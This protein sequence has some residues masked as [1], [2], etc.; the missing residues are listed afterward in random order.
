MVAEINGV[1]SAELNLHRHLLWLAGGIAA[2]QGGR[3][4]YCHDPLGSTPEAD[5]F[6]LRIRYGIDAWKTWSWRASAATTASAT[7]SPAPRMSLPGP[8]ATGTTMPHSPGWL[9]PPGET[10][11][12]RDHSRGPLD[13]QPPA[14][15]RHPAVARVDAYHVLEAGR[16]RQRWIG[17]DDI[18]HQHE[19]RK[20]HRRR[21]VPSAASGMRSV[22]TVHTAN[23][24]R[25]FGPMPPLVPA[26]P[27]R[28]RHDQ[29]GK[30]TEVWERH[31]ISPAF[32]PQ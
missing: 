11:T 26:R 31:D 29:H 8:A 13:L 12:G 18:V 16:G 10:P 23:R 2:L 27:C 19:G 24:R 20:L 32:Y 4:F 7:C 5:H 21:P 30:T 6:I 25:T 28:D 1:A 15:K 3:C 22:G 17:D 9:P 14:T